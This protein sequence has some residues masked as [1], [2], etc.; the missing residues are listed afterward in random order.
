MYFS[1]G[2]NGRPFSS[3]YAMVSW[4]DTSTSALP[5]LKYIGFTAGNIFCIFFYSL[6]LFTKSKDFCIPIT[7]DNPLKVYFFNKKYPSTI[8]TRPTQ[9]VKV[10]FLF[11][12][13]F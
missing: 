8:Q 11:K 13:R 1:V 10:H 4:S 6:T 12:N 9:I 5:S 7:F 2:L 3:Q